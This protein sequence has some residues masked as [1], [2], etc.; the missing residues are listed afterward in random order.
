VDDIIEVQDKFYVINKPKEWSSFDVVKKIR[1]LGRFKKIGHAGTLDPLA[2]GILIMC[3]GKY[4]KKI[5]Y[6]QSLP[7]TYTG[8]MVIGKTTPSI[9][10]ET[11]FDGDYP[12]EH[13]DPNL[14][15][16]VR[17]TFLGAIK[18]VPPIYSAIKLNGQR[19]FTHARNGVSAEDLDI[20]IRDAEVFRMEIDTANFPEISF[21][22]EC[23]KGTYIRSI[24]RDFGLKCESG[25]YMSEL[26]RTKIGDWGLD[27]AQDVATFNSELHEVLL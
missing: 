15:E 12:I 5:D 10:L 17:K 11:E 6:F 25:A 7:K 4:T 2:T 3:V 19:L 13:I 27:K 21:E 14:L 26:V 22:I 16:E 18:Q 9:D 24:V 20:K 1:N 8:K 23:S